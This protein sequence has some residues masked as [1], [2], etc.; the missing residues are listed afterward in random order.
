MYDDFLPYESNAFDLGK[1]MRVYL[2]IERDYIQTGHSRR[3]CAHE[4]CVHVLDAETRAADKA[5]VTD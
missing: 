1:W 3:A 2:H 4:G 5:S